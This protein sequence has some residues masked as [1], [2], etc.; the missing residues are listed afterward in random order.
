MRS[1]PDHL[2]AP[3][4]RKQ[5]Q[6]WKPANILGPVNI[7]G[8]ANTFGSASLLNSVMREIMFFFF[9]HILKDGATKRGFALIFESEEIQL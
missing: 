5:L 7:V 2:P 8:P 1:N 6:I 9:C 4:A 3:W